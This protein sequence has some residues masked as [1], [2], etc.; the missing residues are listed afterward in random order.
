MIGKYI[1]L[2]VAVVLCAVSVLL[3]VNGFVTWGVIASI[4]CALFVLFHFKNEMNLWAFYFVRKNKFAKAAVILDKVKHPE[5]MIK[6]QEAYFYFLSGLTEAQKGQRGTKAEK[7]LKKALSTGLRMK[8]DQAMA[9]LNLAGYYLSRR[10]KKL[11]TYYIKET[12][13]LDTRKML[14]D[15]IKEVENMMKRI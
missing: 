8:T 2:I 13:K 10:N 11:A 7:L 3:F 1:R 14:T 15:Q 5:W 6:G 9:K 4:L 12:K